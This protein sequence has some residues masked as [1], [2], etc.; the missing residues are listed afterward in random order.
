MASDRSGHDDSFL[1]GGYKPAEGQA[2][3]KPEPIFRS[4]RARLPS[5]GQRLPTGTPVAFEAAFGW[6]WLVG[7][8]EDVTPSG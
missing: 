1:P 4:E 7:L 2:D 3:R 6:G 5:A 8:L